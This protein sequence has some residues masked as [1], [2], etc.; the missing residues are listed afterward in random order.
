MKTP[1]HIFNAKITKLFSIFIDVT[2]ITL[3]PFIIYRSSK[4]QVSEV[5]INHESIHIEQQKELFVIPFYILYVYFW[6]KNKYWNKMSSQDSYFN[7]PFE[8]EAYSN[9]YNLSY[10][11]QRKK[12]SWREYV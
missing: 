10:I 2:A 1:I 11:D 7:I 8:K 6:M 3:Y 5:T 9:H 12:H 4:D